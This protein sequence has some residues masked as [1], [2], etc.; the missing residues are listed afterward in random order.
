MARLPPEGELLK[1]DDPRRN[2]PPPLLEGKMGERFLIRLDG[3]GRYSVISLGVTEIVIDLSDLVA[4]DQ[5]LDTWRDFAKRKELGFTG[6]AWRT[7]KSNG[8]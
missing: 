3:G 2:P 1:A 6:P 7:C 4:I 8:H 5:A